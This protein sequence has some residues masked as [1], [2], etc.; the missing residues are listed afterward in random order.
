M[1][2]QLVVFLA[3][4]LVSSCFLTQMWMSLVIRLLLKLFTCTLAVSFSMFLESFSFYFVFLGLKQLF[5]YQ[6]FGE[7][8]FKLIIYYFLGKSPDLLGKVLFGQPFYED[9]G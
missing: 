8:E 6:G 9:F 7:Q 2:H 1:K 4:L 5:L 3:K